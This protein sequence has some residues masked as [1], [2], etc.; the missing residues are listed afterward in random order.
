[1]KKNKVAA[2]FRVAEFDIMYNEGISTT[3]DLLD[4]GV[5]Y[6]ILTKRGAY[7]SFG[8]ERVGQGR[9]ASKEFLRN[10]K[11]MSALIDGQIRT[12]VGLPAR[13]APKVLTSEP[14]P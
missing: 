11:D 13:G 1:M 8:D 6:D 9:E 12:K 3:G 14:K 10:R 7:F 4:L 2:P 5:E